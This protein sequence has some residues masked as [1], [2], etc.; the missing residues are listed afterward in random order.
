MNLGGSGNRIQV[1]HN[2]TYEFV[3][4]PS[5]LELYGRSAYASRLGGNDD[6]AAALSGRRQCDYLARGLPFRDQKAVR[7]IDEHSGQVLVAKKN[8]RRL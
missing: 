5:C 2:V 3:D 7:T 1:L 4:P 6:I 8:W